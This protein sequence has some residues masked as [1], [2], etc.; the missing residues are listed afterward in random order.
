MILPR[1][2]LALFGVATAVLPLVGRAH[3]HIQLGFTAGT[4]DLHVLDIESGRFA[5][6]E[7]PFVVAALARQPTPAD[8]RY[9]PFLGSSGSVW[10]LPQTEVAGLLNLGLGTSGI[11]AGIFSGDQ[12]RLRL[13]RVDGPGDFA[14]FTLSQFG[15]PVSPL[16]SRDGSDPATDFLTLP[17]VNGHVHV[18]W[19][20]NAPGVYRV[21]L[22]ATATLAATGQTLASPVTDY[23]FFVE[24]PPS[25]VLGPLVLRPDGAWD[26]TVKAPAGQTFALESSADL[27]RWTALGPFVGTGQAEHLSLPSGNSPSRYLRATVP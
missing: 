26:L 19:A 7:Y 27:R 5:P 18:N 22:Q 21:G 20:F 17:A 16:A 6:A 14:L 12:V 9:H 1:H 2:W 15:V 23:V 11:A 24:A 10:I 4:W 13:H 8:V 25:P 3:V